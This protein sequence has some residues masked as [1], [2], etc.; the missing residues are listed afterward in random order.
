[1]VV[2]VGILAICACMIDIAS[3]LLFPLG[4]MYRHKPVVWY[5]APPAAQS[6]HKMSYI[7]VAKLQVR[8]DTCQRREDNRLDKRSGSAAL[9]L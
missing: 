5:P 8:T 3:F 6:V 7:Q 4:E 1:M 9:L 2:V